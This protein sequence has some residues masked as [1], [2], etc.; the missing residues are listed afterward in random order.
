[1]EETLLN[2]KW[3]SCALVRA[4][5]TF[6]Q[7]LLSMVTV[8]QAFTDVTWI[9]VLSVS[10][11]AALLSICTS[12]AGIGEVPSTLDAHEEQ[13]IVEECTDEEEADTPYEG[14]GD[15]AES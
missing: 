15:S 9:N 5:K 14:D 1:M 12:V 13:V 7:T 10:A 3:W 6:C 8:G 2:R 11:V 4:L